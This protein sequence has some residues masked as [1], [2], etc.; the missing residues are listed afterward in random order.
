MVT[1]HSTIIKFIL[2]LN[3]AFSKPQIQHLTAFVHGM[4]LCDGRLNISQIHRHTNEYRH[5]SCMTRF[6]NES[7]WNSQHLKKQHIQFL[8]N[9]VK[10]ARFKQEDYR[11][12]TFL[13]IDD[14]QCKRINPHQKWK[15]LI[16]IFLIRMEKVFGLTAPF[17]PML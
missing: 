14:T 1:L 13:V 8:L 9:K 2:A 7:P 3:V 6:F 11:P 10:Q 15:G 4:I 17:P 5:L 12:I 16:I